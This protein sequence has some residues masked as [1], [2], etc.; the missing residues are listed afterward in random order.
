M[1]VYMH[2]HNTLTYSYALIFAKSWIK[3]NTKRF[4]LNMTEQKKKSIDFY[5]IMCPI[6]AQGTLQVK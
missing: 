1:H 2:A 4:I 3:F 5:R 6:E